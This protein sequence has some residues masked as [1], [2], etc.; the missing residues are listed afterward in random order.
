MARTAYA[1]LLDDASSTATPRELTEAEEELLRLL[2]ARGVPSLCDAV[3]REMSYAWAV[4]S[5]FRT[6]AAVGNFYF[7]CGSQAFGYNPARDFFAANGAQLALFALHKFV[8]NAA[9]L[10]PALDC[11]HIYCKLHV[12]GAL[13][14]LAVADA[15]EI[16]MKC[17]RFHDNKHDVISAACQ[18]LSS[19]VM[20]ETV[21]TPDLMLEL[22][23]L[24]KRYHASQETCRAV[25]APLGFLV[26]DAEVTA[27]FVDANGIALT[28]AAMRRFVRDTELVWHAIG[29][30]NGLNAKNLRLIVAMYGNAGVS[31]IVEALA[32]HLDTEEIAVEGF[33]LLAKLAAHEDVYAAVNRAKVLDLAYVALFA[34]SGPQHRHTRVELKKTMR[35]FQK[36]TLYDARELAQREQASRADLLLYA[37]FVL[38][39]LLTS[40]LSLY[41]HRSS[42]L[43][44]GVQ[45]AFVDAPWPLAPPNRQS[46]RRSLKDVNSVSDVWSYLL[47]PLHDGLFP[48]RWYN[49]D[50]FADDTASQLG[51]VDRANV[52]LGGLQL[53]LLRV[54]NTT[55]S[56]QQQQPQTCYPPYTRDA[57]RKS[58]LA[59]DAWS[60]ATP[61]TRDR[62][63]QG[64]LAVYPASGYRRFIP[65]LTAASAATGSCGPYCELAQLQRAKWI[66]ASSRALFVEFNLYNPAVDAHCAVTILF[67]FASTGGVLVTTAI[68][69]LHLDPYPGGVFIFAPRFYAELVALALLAWFAHKQ[70][71]KLGRY[72]WFYFIVAGHAADF[73]LVVLWLAAAAVRVQLLARAAHP[74]LVRLAAGSSFVDLSGLVQLLHTER[75]L[76]AG[77]GVLM[78]W[79]LMRFARCL[80]LLERV[81]DKFAR[82]QSL[83]RAFAFVLLLY[84]LGFA[85]A[86]V[87]LLP[88]PE[89]QVRS[90]STSIAAMA[91]SLFRR[92]SGADEEAM[93]GGEGVTAALVF[94]VL[95]QLSTSF[96]VLK[97]ATGASLLEIARRQLEASGMRVVEASLPQKLKHAATRGLEK[98]QHAARE[99]F[100]LPDEPTELASLK[101]VWGLQGGHAG[102]EQL[103][104][105]AAASSSPLL[106]LLS[107]AEVLDGDLDRQLSDFGMRI[108][109]AT[110]KL[111]LFHARLRQQVDE[112]ERLH[113]TW[114]PSV[115]P[116]AST[117]ATSPASVDHL[118]DEEDATLDSVV[119]THVTVVTPA[120]LPAEPLAALLLPGTVTRPAD[121]DG[122]FTEA[123][124]GSH[125]RS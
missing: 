80:K 42:D 73:A 48:D 32:S 100:A 105:L 55:C 60:D 44:L 6:L 88:A 45:R 115:A 12:D 61:D 110:R 8:H 10:V 57:E 74:L 58:A 27:T 21:S 41:N 123:E 43:V 36:C 23:G 98:L 7:A 111:R 86:G 116:G 29:V 99:V 81:A 33:Q 124:V 102:D 52:L 95:F 66:D 38:C 112:K 54:R 125:A 119:S 24:L 113:P 92:R 89:P 77:A 83:L 101:K 64:K 5:G 108:E 97:A 49:G 15:T 84:V 87:L 69:P 71:E 26:T 67:E 72:R 51:V 90:F 118:R 56:S 121:D 30:L 31:R 16:L 47:H 103:L 2:K 75:A 91:R 37:L 85:Q 68:A 93:G 62:L 17:A 28:M 114:S 1:Q 117:A 14:V 59:D 109:D 3:G 78:W 22:L 96:V 94:R 82:A 120:V 63:F 65:R 107:A 35:A 39:F 18:A 50:L 76:L 122:D 70:G 46:P 34:Y 11:L 53:R 19:L 4:T 106:S 9:V 25:L 20:N 13:E 79:H 40:A 104:H